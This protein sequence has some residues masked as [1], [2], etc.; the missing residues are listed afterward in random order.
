MIEMLRAIAAKVGC[1]IP[2][3]H[4][5]ESLSAETHP[6]ELAAQIEQREEE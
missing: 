5:V 4:E 3:G 6:E 1:E 2:H